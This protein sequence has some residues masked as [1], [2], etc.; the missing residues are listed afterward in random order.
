VSSLKLELTDCSAE[1]G[2]RLVE[3][4]RRQ[5][6]AKTR[7][8]IEQLYL[9]HRDMVFHLALRYGGGRRT[10]AEDVTQDVFVTL[11]RK[12]AII[13]DIDD[14]KSW[15]YRVTANQC[16]K[17]LRR[18][19]LTRIPG[20]DWL[21]GQ[22]HSRASDISMTDDPAVERLAAALRGL[23]DKARVAFCMHHLDG[24]PQSEI[25]EILGHSKGYVSKLVSRA[26][27]A[28]REAAK[29]DG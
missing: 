11:V 7:R 28:V 27:T 22:R 9:E 14:P 13:E 26:E 3:S 19:R 15:L 8:R 10:W 20:I 12:S 29:G 24:V 1:A 2:R 16:L 18:E 5:V 23:P 6:S 17:R 21:F 25:A 4:A